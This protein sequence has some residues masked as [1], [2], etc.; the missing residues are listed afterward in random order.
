ML[1]SPRSVQTARFGIR[2]SKHTSVHLV[3]T[4]TGSAYTPATTSG[5]PDRKVDTRIGLREHAVG[6]ADMRRRRELARS[7]VWRTFIAGRPR[8]GAARSSVGVRYQLNA[9]MMTGI[10]SS[11]ARIGVLLKSI[12]C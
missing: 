6:R 5:V 2:N 8:S 12:H 11:I 7:Q 4:I 3:G 1:R 9:V 10:A